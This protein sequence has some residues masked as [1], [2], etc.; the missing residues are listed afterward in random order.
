MTNLITD[1]NNFNNDMTSL[2]GADDQVQHAK[3][4]YN[5]I[6]EKLKEQSPKGINLFAELAWGMVTNLN[7]F[8]LPG[9]KFVRFNVEYGTRGRYLANHYDEWNDLLMVFYKFLLLHNFD[10]QKPLEIAYQVFPAYLK[11]YEK[12]NYT[13]LYQAFLNW[14]EIMDLNGYYV[15]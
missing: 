5:R 3:C 12:S 9:E 4:N 6:L 10:S 2:N 14:S 1:A 11:Q 7:S 15:D 13:I 8:P